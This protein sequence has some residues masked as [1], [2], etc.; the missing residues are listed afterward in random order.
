MKSGRLQH[1][2]RWYHATSIG[3]RMEE[4]H[5]RILEREPDRCGVGLPRPP[6]PALEGEDRLPVHP[7]CGREVVERPV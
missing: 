6:L 1:L 7:S 5:T 3:I 4:S 2:L